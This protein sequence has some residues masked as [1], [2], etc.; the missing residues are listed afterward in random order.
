MC[1]VCIFLDLDRGGGKMAQIGQTEHKSDKLLWI[2]EAV[3][4][5]ARGEVCSKHKA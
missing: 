1:G 3:C 2:P 5:T 4:D